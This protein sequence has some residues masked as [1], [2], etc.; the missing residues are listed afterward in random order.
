MQELTYTSDPFTFEP[1]HSPRLGKLRPRY[2]VSARDGECFLNDVWAYFR[3]TFN[4]QRT[5]HAVP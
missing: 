2:A 1:F 3:L 5:R 4:A